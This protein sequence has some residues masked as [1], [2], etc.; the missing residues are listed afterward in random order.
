MR[1]EQPR[2]VDCRD[3]PVGVDVSNRASVNLC[4]P[5]AAGTICSDVGRPCHSR[6]CRRTAVAAVWILAIARYGVDNAVRIDAT[7]AIIV[8]VGDQQRSVR[9][10]G[11]SADTRKVGGRRWPAVAAVGE[12]TCPGKRRDRAR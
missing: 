9:H 10:P 3:H 8:S 12:T 2:N 11:H 1:P 6:G 7:N 5:E 4:D